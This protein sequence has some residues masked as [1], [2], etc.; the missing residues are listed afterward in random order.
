MVV[1]IW[2]VFTS[3][4][5]IL[6]CGDGGDGVFVTSSSVR[7][8]LCEILRNGIIPASDPIFI[9]FNEYLRTLG[10]DPIL[11]TYIENNDLVAQK[12][13][14]IYIYIKSTQNF[15]FNNIDRRDNN[16]DSNFIY[17]P[18]IIAKWKGL[19]TKYRNQVHVDKV[20][21][22]FHDFEQIYLTNLTYKSKEQIVNTINTIILEGKAKYVF[23]SS[24]PAYRFIYETQK[25]F[26]SS[27]EAGHFDAITKLC[28]EVIQ[29]ND[30]FGYYTRGK[31]GIYFH[32][33]EDE[34]INLYGLSRED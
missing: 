26:D 27:K 33:C 1:A 12:P 3:S 11:S 18:D 8:Q 25:H 31:I 2:K 19:L 34:N 16:W 24:E 22:F 20:H 5:R 28:H 4:A 7:D 15:D 10:L 30:L 23:C 32:H 21:V 9:E 29:Q 17:T 14:C 6:I 13:S